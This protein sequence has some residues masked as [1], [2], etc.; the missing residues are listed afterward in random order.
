MR[1][2]QYHQDEET[3]WGLTMWELSSVVG[4]VNTRISYGITS[5]TIT[6]L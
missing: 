1:Y 4:L 5:G 6:V 2:S 3:S